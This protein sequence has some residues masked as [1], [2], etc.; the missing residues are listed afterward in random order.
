MFA[1]LL[2]EAQSNLRAVIDRLDGFAAVGRVLLRT[3]LEDVHPDAPPFT[4]LR[5]A[6]VAL[7]AH[8]AALDRARA[9][10]G[11]TPR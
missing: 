11:A 7:Q 2:I 6:D 4:H 8:K 3:A 1:S 5:D 10:M 9:S